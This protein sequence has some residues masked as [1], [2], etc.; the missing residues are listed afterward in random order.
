[1]KSTSSITRLAAVLTVLGV[2]MSVPISGT[3]G[4]SAAEDRERRLAFHAVIHGNANP[5][6]ID[7]CTLGNHEAGSGRAVHLGV[8]T[9]SSDETA[10]FLS[11]S[12]PSPPGPAIAVSG[13]FIIVAANGDEI[14]GT[15]QTTGTF[16][17]VNGVSVHGGYTFVS[18]TG[19]FSTV[20]GSGVIV[21][22]GAASP[23]FDFVASLDGTIKYDRL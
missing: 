8:I 4:A 9:W 19:R 15:Y 2:A 21:A 22:H 10:Q 6:P 5:F 7:P 3:V 17:P 13:Q 23:P 1:M 16:D 12:P 18:G 11:C 20:T 14:H